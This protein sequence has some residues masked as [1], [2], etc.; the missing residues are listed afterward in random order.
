MT[1]PSR[2]ALVER[3]RSA[4][5]QADAVGVL[6]RWNAGESPEP[7]GFGL[8]D[9]RIDLRGFTLTNP[10][11]VGSLSLVGLGG[12]KRAGCRRGSPVP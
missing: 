12:A 11:E 3:W 7:T 10:A 5:G 8:V 1:V 4:Q 2:A 9:G 6:R